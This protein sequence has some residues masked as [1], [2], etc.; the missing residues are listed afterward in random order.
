MLKKE[1]FNTSINNIF[2][3]VSYKKLQIDTDKYIYIF[4][5]NS[6][7]TH[8]HINVLYLV[9]NVPLKMMLPF[10]DKTQYISLFQFLRIE[11]F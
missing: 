4:L 3:L 7:S 6:S 8:V 10:E 1:L 2:F 9:K 5:M 11:R